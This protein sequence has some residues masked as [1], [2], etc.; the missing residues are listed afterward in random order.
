MKKIKMIFLV[1]FFISVSA[2]GGGS[3]GKNSHFEHLDDS[4]KKEFMDVMLQVFTAMDVDNDGYVTEA[5]AKLV[6]SEQFLIKDT[7]G[8]GVIEQEDKTSDANT[9]YVIP[10]DKDGDGEASK[11]EYDAFYYAIFHD[12]LD[13][14]GSGRVSK[15]EFIEAFNIF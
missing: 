1:S 12:K 15:D 3:S 8:D 11:E 14:N 6:F 2:C 13:L 4:A 5:E 9:T 7:D 10:Y